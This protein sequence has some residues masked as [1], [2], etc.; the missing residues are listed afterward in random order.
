M[1]SVLGAHQR[2]CDGIER[3]DVLRVGALGGIGLALPT[4]LQASARGRSDA[5]T[6][7]RARHCLLLFLTG[8]APQH[9]TWDLK[10]DAPAEIRGEL[11][12]IATDAP[13]VLISELF[14]RLARHAGKCCVL[15]SMTHHDSIHTSA[16]YSMLT[17]VPHPLAN[18]RSAKDIRPTPDDHPHLGALLAKVHR[19][20]EGMPVF[21]SL[22]EVVK[23]AGVNEFPGQGAGFLGAGYEPFRIQGNA[24]SGEFQLPDIFLPADVSAHRLSDRRLLLS[25]LDRGLAEREHN[26]VV[27]DFGGYYEQAFRLIGSP[28][29]RS[30]FDLGREPERVHESYGKHLFGQGCLLARRL[31]EAGVRLVTVYWHYEGP[32]DSPVWDTHQNNYPHLRNRLMPPTDQALAAV[33]ADLAERGLLD[34]TLV[35]C[36]GEFGRSP[37]INR[38]GGRDHWPLVQSVMLAGAGLRAGCVYGASDRI[39]AYPDDKPAAPSDLAATILHLLG[40]PHDLELRDR[41]GRPMRA[42]EGRVLRELWA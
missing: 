16:G 3:R 27:A 12:P 23:D 41:A 25:Q 33:L 38:H 36:M 19:P 22:P 9:D 17:G 32:D 8:G 39:G 30:A 20:R 26:L 2:L 5:P 37:K 11:Q 21:A 28:G 1:L 24:A 13:G 7:G 10:P 31:L 6:F 15:R 14:P 29:A 34:S 18:G 42:C 35:V 40:V 4:L